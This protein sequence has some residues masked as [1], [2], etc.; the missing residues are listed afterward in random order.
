[1]LGLA[2]FLSLSLS[3]LLYFFRTAISVSYWKPCQPAV[4]KFV[5]SLLIMDIGASAQ[6]VWSISLPA[7]RLL[8]EVLLFS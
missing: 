1:M 5:S 4:L 8:F 2:L 6:S 3:F 7:C